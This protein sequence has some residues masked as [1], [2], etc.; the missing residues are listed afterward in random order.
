L[1]TQLDNINFVSTFDGDYREITFAPGVNNIANNS[2][3]YTTSSSTFNTFK[4]FSIKIVMTGTNTTDVPKVQD[5]R[6]IALP[7]V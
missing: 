4:T 7:A 2:V 5:V 1:M 3:T 6:V